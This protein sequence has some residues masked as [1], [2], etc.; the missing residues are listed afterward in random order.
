MRN[1]IFATAVAM[2][3]C[4]LAATAHGTPAKAQFVHPDLGPFEQF[5]PT[6]TWAAANANISGAPIADIQRTCACQWK[7]MSVGHTLRNASRACVATN[8][9]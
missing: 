9:W 8:G 7:L 6:C 2:A 1:T 5:V 4:V 3:G